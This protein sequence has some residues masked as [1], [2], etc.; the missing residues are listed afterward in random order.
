ML[1]KTLQH[2]ECLALMRVSLMHMG[3]RP[4]S[5][6]CIE[7][8]SVKPTELG[9]P[10]RGDDGGKKIT[11]RTWH[12]LVDTLGVLRAVLRTSAG[13]DDGVAAPLLLGHV[14]PPDFPRLVTIVADTKD[15]QHA[16]AAWLAAHRAEWPLAVQTRP[17]GTTGFTPLETRW[18]VERTNAGDGR[19]RSNSKDYERSGESS[20]VMIQISNINRMLNRLAPCGRPQCHYRKNAA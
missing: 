9:G 15:H 6:A 17:E 20:T 2:S 19:S 8:P 13:L 3:S 18:V 14:M 16:L 7:S 10:A 11:G 4:P 12:L 1:D 5:A